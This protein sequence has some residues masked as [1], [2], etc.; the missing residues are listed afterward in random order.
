[1]P[2]QTLQAGLAAMDRRLWEIQA[3]LETGR[4]TLPPRTFSTV[5]T[6]GAERAAEAPA[7]PPAAQPPEPPARPPQ[8]HAQPREPPARIAPALDPIIANL[9]TALVAAIREL[10]GADPERAPTV[11][12]LSAGPF[13]GTKAL[14][15]FEREL[16]A[17]PTV[18]EVSLSGFEPG[19]RAVIEV[20]L[21]STT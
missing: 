3:E 10:L 13:T 9:C 8:P 2:E 4:E 18:R 20:Q 17:L 5:E 19:N 15:E 14:R 7:A 6:R 12:N 21:R 1:M 11:L 16:A